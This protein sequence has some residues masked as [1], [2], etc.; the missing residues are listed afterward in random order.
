VALGSWNNQFELRLV[1][2]DIGD[3]ME[4]SK[5]DRSVCWKIRMKT[6]GEVLEFI[7]SVAQRWVDNGLATFEDEETVETKVETAAINKAPQTAARN[8]PPFRQTR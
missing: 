5:R 3:F 7:P 2:S 4:L 6:S 1:R 8:K